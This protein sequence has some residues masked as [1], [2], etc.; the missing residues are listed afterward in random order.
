MTATL[1]AEVLIVDDED[2]MLRILGIILERAG[3]KPLFAR[4]G[5]EALDAIKTYRPGVVILDDMLPGGITGGD[6]CAR[7]KEDARLCNI[8]IIMHSAGVKIQS[9]SYLR[10][11]G[12][13]AALFKP[14]H[15]TRILE[16]I[17]GF[18]AVGA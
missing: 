18:L 1:T 9:R 11:I 2:G 3:F 7:V 16:A 14:C 6:V 17:N 13:D 15:P 8:P 12:A 4:N 5:K 10:E